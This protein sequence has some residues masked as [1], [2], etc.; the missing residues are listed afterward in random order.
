MANDDN[1]TE[2]DKEALKQLEGKVLVPKIGH[3]TLFREAIANAT[4]I[5]QGTL[6]YKGMAEIFQTTGIAEHIGIDVKAGLSKE[7][8]IDYIV[9]YLKDMYLS[10]IMEHGEWIPEE[11]AEKRRKSTEVL[12]GAKEGE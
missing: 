7:E 6:G 4:H 11:E 1:L 3:E 12:F 8:E 9:K 2:E 10:S 5:A